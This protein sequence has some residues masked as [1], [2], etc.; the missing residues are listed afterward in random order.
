MNLADLNI[1]ALD[2]QATGAGPTNGHLLEI[3]WVKSRAA[4]EL[5]PQTLSAESDFVRLP[6]EVEIPPAVQRVTGLSKAVL[7][8]T[9]PA[10]DIW[11]KIITLARGIAAI[12]RLEHCPTVI[13]YARYEE[14]FLRHLH[15]ES[16]PGDAFP[17]RIICSHEIARRLLPGLP[18]K[19]LRAVAGF[20]GHS[21]PQLRRGKEHAVATAII[22]HH[23]IRQL[24]VEH[25]IQNLDQLTDWLN[26]TPVQRRTERVYPMKPEVRLHLP[27]K[28]G[29]Y[30]MRRSNGDLLYIGKATSL[31][32]RVNSYFGQKGVRAEHT[33][34]MLSQAVDLDVTLTGSALEAAVLES[35]EIKRF[36]PPYNVALQKGQRK[37]VFC[38][39]DLQT[40]A[41]KPDTTHCV[42]PL[43]D[44]NLAAA[45]TAFG[46]WHANGMH[47][48]SDDW[49][50]LG[51]AILG[52]PEPYAPPPECLAEG[53]DLFRSNHRRRM[54]QCL[55]LRLLTGLG[56][57][58]WGERLAALEKTRLK[59]PQETAGEQ[60]VEEEMESPEEPN[61]TPEAVAR[62]VEH[63]VMHSA[64]LIRRARW[65]C[66]LSESTVSWEERGS[67]ALSKNVLLLENA[68]VSRQEQLPIEVKTPAPPGYSKRMPKRQRMFNVTTYE[69]LRVITT[70][71]RRLVTEGRRIEIRLKPNAVLNHKQIARILPWV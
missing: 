59:P 38:S 61:W 43:F 9:L 23:L 30:R 53:L 56:Y 39:N 14:P 24:R 41:A 19:G 8:K 36:A 25:D 44:G 4:D 3:G 48:D 49:L 15:A 33:L 21:V 26:R 10:S 45:V 67:P 6:R 13:H 28:P 64:L 7:K 55:P 63:V 62:A 66:L 50:P 37:L 20:F 31:K 58:L 47:A 52:V 51:T 46:A 54:Q 40:C 57:S 2:S 29:I 70:E 22:W 16:H 1:L 32:Q 17:L 27:D 65:L 60:A 71:L 69:R 68:S 34:E 42:G 35:D 5:D 12:D 11:K 18:R